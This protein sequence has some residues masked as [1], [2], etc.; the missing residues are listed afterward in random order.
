MSDYPVSKFLF[1]FHLKLKFGEFFFF[2]ILMLPIML[3]PLMDGNF[4]NLFELRSIRPTSSVFDLFV[5]ISSS[6]SSSWLLA[7]ER[8]FKQRGFNFKTSL[9]IRLLSR[10]MDSRLLKS[11]K[12]PTEMNSIWLFLKSIVTKLLGKFSG[13]SS[14]ASRLSL[15]LSE[16]KRMVDTFGKC[17]N[18]W[19]SRTRR[20]V[21]LK[22]CVIFSELKVFSFRNEEFLQSMCTVPLLSP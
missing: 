15:M 14:L 2:W 5:S 12:N 1:K 22:T 6:T 7:S 3:Y 11:A 13:Y 18:A 20:V 17:S 9:R 19:L 8:W 10:M 16:C 4:A 21:A